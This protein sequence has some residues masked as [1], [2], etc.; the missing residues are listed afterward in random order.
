MT[1]ER[2]ARSVS[3]LVNKRFAVPQPGDLSD[4]LRGPTTAWPVIDMTKLRIDLIEH[5]TAVDRW[6]C[7]LAPTLDPALYAYYERPSG[8]NPR[9]A[10]VMAVTRTLPVDG[11]RPQ[12]EAQMTRGNWDE[13]EWCVAIDLYMDDDQVGLVGPVGMFPVLVAA[14]GRLLDYGVMRPFGDIPEEQVLDTC[15]LIFCAGLNFL[16]C[17]NVTY[18]EPKRDRAEQRR[19]MRYG[20]TVNELVVRPTRTSAASPPPTGEGMPLTT[21]RGHFAHYGEKYGRAR[22]FGVLEGRYWIPQHARGSAEYGVV[23]NNYRLE[24]NE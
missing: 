10:V 18:V 20:I 23:K 15:L 22:L 7:V 19:I 1:A 2:I 9:G 24:P 11:L 5:R 4:G 3:R 12:F 6:K 14:D 16:N 8:D 17:V 21:V 13:A